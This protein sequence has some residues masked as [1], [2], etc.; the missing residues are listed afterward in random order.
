L[1]TREVEAK[2]WSRVNAHLWASYLESLD[3]STESIA[4]APQL[5]Y[6]VVLGLEHA[7]KRGHFFLDGVDAFTEAL[8]LP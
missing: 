3:F 6:G 4:F 1:V 2:I 7:V 8:I 5:L